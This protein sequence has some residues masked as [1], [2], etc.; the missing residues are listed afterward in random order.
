M[1]DPIIEEVRKVRDAHA[2]RFN[3]DLDAIFRD[4]KEKEKTSG[5]SFVSFAP[6]HDRGEARAA[7]VAGCHL[8]RTAFV[9]P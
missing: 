3:Y 5:R 6:P 7:A 9:A 8:Y 2:S 1:I 4:I